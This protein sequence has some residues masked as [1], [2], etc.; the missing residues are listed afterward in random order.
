M[1]FESK[2]DQ[3]KMWQYEPIPDA[4]GIYATNQ[5]FSSVLPGIRAFM[6]ATTGTHPQTAYLVA[7]SER[8]STRTNAVVFYNQGLQ[9]IPPIYN[10]SWG[11]YYVQSTSA[12]DY[13][14]G[15]YAHVLAVLNGQNTSAGTYYDQ[16][17]DS[18]SGGPQLTAQ[19]VVWS[20]L[21]FCDDNDKARLCLYY[22]IPFVQAADMIDEANSR[23]AVNSD[24]DP[25]RKPI[26]EEEDQKRS[27]S[28]MDVSQTSIYFNFSANY[29]L[30][31]QPPGVFYGNA[32]FKLV[33]SGVS[34]AYSDDLSYWV[35][36]PIPGEL[37]QTYTLYGQNGYNWR[38]PVNGFA[39]AG[40][41]GK[42]NRSQET[43]TC[44]TTDST[45]TVTFTDLIDNVNVVFFPVYDQG[46]SNPIIKYSWDPELIA[47][48]G[49]G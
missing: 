17:G 8:K 43:Y 44:S 19:Q 48:A 6:Q 16:N 3:L 9:N 45:L 31:A 29:T 38:W 34:L 15:L 14:T 13:D 39:A 32:N 5:N 12:K 46:G 10:P 27:D 18:H 35:L 1:S 2:M 42:L 49:G 30:I 40:F 28:L 41:S 47:T 7:M 36:K 22:P 37:I 11:V 21:T 26:G 25:N 23:N 4:D 24:H 20:H 33:V